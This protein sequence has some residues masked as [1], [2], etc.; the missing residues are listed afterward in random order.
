[1]IPKIIHY[2]WFGHGEMSEKAKMCVDSWKK[3]CPEYEIKEWNEKNFDLNACAYIKEAYDAKKW[4]FVSDYARFEILYKYGGVYFDTDVEVIKPLD[5]IIEKGS[6][7]GFQ[8]GKKTMREIKYEVNPGLGVASVPKLP[9]FKEILDYYHS[10]HFTTEDGGQN[11]ETIVD[12]TTKIL[13]KHGMKNKDTIQKVADIILYPPDFFCPLDFNTGILNITDN[14]Y[15]IHHFL[16][17]WFTPMDWA[18]LKIERRFSN[19][20][21]LKY[22]L[23]KFIMLPLR[24]IRKINNIGMKDSLKLA[25][26]KFKER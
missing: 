9:L 10:I 20:G 5:K 25:I 11:F 8:P 22:A 19:G 17:S 15:S 1:M 14:T 23:G 21:F 7:M 2:C 18:I 12:Y 26:K 3:Y 16:A 24:L 13:K 6:F 4:A